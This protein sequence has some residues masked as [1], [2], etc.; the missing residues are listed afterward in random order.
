[1]FKGFLSELQSSSTLALTG[2]QKLTLL[3]HHISTPIYKCFSG[4][5]IYDA[6]IST[7]DGMFIKKK[8]SI[9]A[10]YL[11]ATQRQ[12]TEESLKLYLQNLKILSHDC[13]FTTLT[14]SQ[15][16]DIAIRDAFISG[17][18]SKKIKQRMLKNKELDLGTAYKLA[19]MLDMAQKPSDFYSQPDFS[20]ATI[21]AQPHSQQIP[22]SNSQHCDPQDKDSSNMIEKPVTITAAEIKCYFCGLCKHAH[23][24]CPA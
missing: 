23:S 7:L 5:Q 22:I 11:L 10:R 24:S 13:D 18:L 21:P 17:V 12:E 20:G 19:L 4:C 3:L 14:T 16:R 6:A 15:A 1:M 8:N 2:S 9:F